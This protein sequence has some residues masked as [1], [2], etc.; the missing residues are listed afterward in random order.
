MK[1][2]HRVKVMH[3]GRLW[4]IK[5]DKNNS[6]LLQFYEEICSQPTIYKVLTERVWLQADSFYKV[7]M[8]FLN[9]VFEWKLSTVCMFR[10]FRTSLAEIF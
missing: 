10:T 4:E 1:I 9:L 2:I 5:I 3:E 8:V 6:A 7:L